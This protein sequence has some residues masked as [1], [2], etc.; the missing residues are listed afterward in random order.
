MKNLSAVWQ[1]LREVKVSGLEA[2]VLVATLGF[3]GYVAYFYFNEVRPIS[4]QIQAVKDESAALRSKRA[5]EIK[6]AAAR[7][8]QRIQAEQIKNS[9][10]NFEGYLR[11][12][13]TGKAALIDELEDL[14]KKHKILTGDMG[15]KA[16]EAQPLVDENGQL[17]REAMRS[18]KLDVYPALGLDTSVIGDY[19]NL[20]RFLADVE[21]NRQFWVINAI[22]FQ[23]EADKA[24]AVGKGRPL[25]LG[26]DAVPVTLKV[27]ME[28]FFRK[29][30]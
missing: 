22:A 24:R 19:P 29:E 9:L 8:Q 3:G 21:K 26:P 15:F 27:E 5:E 11:I 10:Y 18:D 12:S 17:L 30:Q 14:A 4:G 16:V 20:R 6:V 1:S 23:G 7:E 25:Q 13:E 28:S 2:V